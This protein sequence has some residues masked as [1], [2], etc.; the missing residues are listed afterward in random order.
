MLGRI[1]RYLSNTAGNTAMIFALGA[2]PLLLGIGAAVDYSRASQAKE[3]LQAAVDSAAL[4]ALA[5]KALVADIIQG[6]G[7]ATLKARVVNYLRLNKASEALS[8]LS[9]ISVKYD[10]VSKNV[11]VS[12]LGNLDTAMMKLGGISSMDIGAVAEIGIGITALEVALVLDNT[13][14]MKGQKIADLKAA[15]TMLVDEVL[16]SE[17]TAAYLALGIVPFSEY[18]NIGVGTK[19]H[20]WLD[21]KT[22]PAGTNW[23]GCVGSRPSPQDESIRMNSFDKYTPVGGENCGEPLLN[24]TSDRKAIDMK[25][26]AMGAEGR[27][28]IPAGLLWGWNLLNADHPFADA[29]EP[30]QLAE[31]GGQ[32]VL[33]LMT[34]GANTVS[35]KETPIHDG[36][37]RAKADVLTAKLCNNV[38]ADNIKIF[39]VAFKVDDDNA[40]SMLVAC[41]SEPDMAFDA[42]DSASLKAAFLNIGRQLAT[43]H[44]AR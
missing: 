6:K 24:L 20:G 30:R 25:I 33:V 26:G 13:G 22:Y 7:E 27:T 10:P 29:K 32:K 39:T 18:V 35:A 2:L 40:K 19:T 28:Y 42:T 34:D 11:I 14:S 38:K 41:A 1:R 12:V 36:N 9:E 4:G 23:E 3:S 31:L 16:G 43:M 21:N 8:S 37:D 17:K 15:A 5:D 44:L